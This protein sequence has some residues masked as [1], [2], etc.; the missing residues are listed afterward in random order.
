MERFLIEGLTVDEIKDL[1]NNGKKIGFLVTDDNNL[2]FKAAPGQL[3]EKVKKENGFRISEQYSDQIDF[4]NYTDVLEDTSSQ[5]YLKVGTRDNR[6][7]IGKDKII[8]SYEFEA[9][10]NYFGLNN[11]KMKKDIEVKTDEI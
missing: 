5:K 3:K 8:D 4:E 10:V 1:Y 6:D 9:Y 7:R 2:Y 11:L